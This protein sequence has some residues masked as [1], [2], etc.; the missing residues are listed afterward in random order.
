M[1]LNNLSISELSNLIINSEITSEDI[2]GSY[3][4]RIEETDGSLK[5]FITIN[6]EEA[7]AEA[8][9]IDGKIKKG[10]KVGALAGIPLAIKDN[11]MTAGIKT[12]CGSRFLEDFI[13]PY[14]AT[15]I[16]NLKEQGAIII[17]KTNLDEFAM[18]SSTENSAFFSTRNPWDIQRVPGGSSGGSAVAVASGQ[19]PL[20][21]GS[22]TGGSIRQPSSFCGVVGLK[23]TYGLVS[24][25]G[26]VAFASSLDQIG[27]MARSVEDC[28]VGLNFIAA[29]DPLDSTSAKIQTKDYTRNLNS[30]IKGLKIGLPREY[31][32]DVIDDNVRKMV[33]EAVDNLRGLGVEIREISLPHTKYA[34]STYQ[35]ISSVE[36]S[37]NLS[38]FDGIRYGKRANKAT[39]IDELIVESRSEG[40]GQEVKTRIMMGMYFLSEGCKE[41]YYQRAIKA[42]ALIKEDFKRIFDEVD[43]I[44]SPTTP[45]PAFKIGAKDSKSQDRYLADTLTVATNLSG[46]PAVSVPCGIIDNMPIGMQIIGDYFE[47]EKILQI[48]YNYEKNIFKIGEPPSL[49]G[50]KN[51]I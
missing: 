1:N 21:L 10:E 36:A 48:A 49:R 51:E 24:R 31:F 12:T 6:K 28:G 27:P 33:L 23:P 7:L 20:A 32:T 30:S 29:F 4:K 15:V 40:F 41:K 42:R 16:K 39:T 45:F 3:I 35:I 46:L 38:R 26:L 22:S 25:Y 44:I 18:G 11:I 47:E 17:G 37:S 8:R 9:K 50:D 5:A 13:S 19:S 2:V 14:D 34:L 43:A